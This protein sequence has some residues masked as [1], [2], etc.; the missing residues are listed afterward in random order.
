MAQYHRTGNFNITRLLFTQIG[1]A[2][3]ALGLGGYATTPGFVTFP[4]WLG[5]IWLGCFL[6]PASRPPLVILISVIVICISALVA[7]PLAQHLAPTILLAWLTLALLPLLFIRNPYVWIWFL[8]VWLIHAAICFWQWFVLD[9]PRVSGITG[10]ANSAAALLLLGCVYLLNGQGRLKWIMLPLL[11]GILFTGSRWTVGVTAATLLILFISKH[12]NWR[13]IAVGIVVAVAITLVT[14]WRSLRTTWIRGS[15]L[16]EHLTGRGITSTAT[17]TAK[18]SFI[19]QGFTDNGIHSVP[20]RLMFE[21]GVLSGVAWLVASGYGL[22]RYWR[23][24]DGRWWMFLSVI[25]IS[26]M[27]YHAWLGPLAGFWWL[28]VRPNRDGAAPPVPAVP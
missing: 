16:E 10:N 22:F 7:L 17:E 26:L 28:L 23:E 21:T 1:A 14:D 8:P 20:I 3:I 11:V 6:S 12:V 18:L 24:R 5:A 13:Y 27:Y 15:T 19:P 4:F 2:F 9:M 25:L